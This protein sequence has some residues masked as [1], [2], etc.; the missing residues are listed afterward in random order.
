MIVDLSDNSKDEGDLDLP[1]DRINNFEKQL[2]CTFTMRQGR[3]RAKV[4]KQ[5]QIKRKERIIINNNL[6]IEMEPCRF[7]HIAP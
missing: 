2:L 7:N 3:I 6:D 5:R 4:A 1:V